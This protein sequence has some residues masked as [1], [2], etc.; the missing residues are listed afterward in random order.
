MEIISLI[1]QVGVLSVLLVFGIKIGLAM[2]FAGIS[3]K[4]ASLIILGYALGIV[5]LTTVANAYMTSVQGFFTQYATAITIIMAA[6]IMYAGFHTIN[7]WKQKQKNTAKATCL[8]MIAPCPCCFGAVIASIVIFSPMIGLSAATLGYYSAVV[9]AV[10]ITIFYL[11]SGLIV[12]LVKKPYPVLLGNFMLF[13]GLY[14]MASAIVLPNINSVLS[15][16]MTP[17]TLPEIQTLIYVI[18]GSAALICAGIF[19]NK[20]KSTLIAK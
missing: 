3:K 8:A 18:I 14:F 9:L 1:W 16:Q 15:Q 10:F 12:L 2:G 6:V 17:M 7:E 11:L 19:I 4:I 20:K 13:A 5:A